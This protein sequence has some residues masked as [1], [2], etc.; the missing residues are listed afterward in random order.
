M[1]PISRF[2]PSTEF[3]TPERCRI[4]EIHNDEG[5]AACSIA[6]ARVAPGVTTQLHSLRGT[7]ERYVILDGKGAVEVDGR[8]PAPIGPLDVV[9]I[10]QGASQRITNTGNVDLIFLCVCTP[11]FKQENYV[12]MDG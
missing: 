4:V 5:D 7:I 6:R 12:T 1:K 8:A 11:R 9:C 2:D 3:S 10:P